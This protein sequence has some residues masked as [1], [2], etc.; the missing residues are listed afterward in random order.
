MTPFQSWSGQKPSMNNLRVFGCVAYS[1]I[2]KDERKKLDPKARRCIFLGY[3]DVTKGYRLYD[4]I[5]ARLIHSRDVVFDETSL[6][7]EKEQIKDLEGVNKPVVEIDVSTEESHS[8]A[9]EE[10][11]VN[12]D[13]TNPNQ[14]DEESSTVLRHSE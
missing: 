7:F 4:T 10:Q 5:K 6:G 12:E 11:T 1:Q 3:G 13:E 9:E 14:S 8:E 2:P